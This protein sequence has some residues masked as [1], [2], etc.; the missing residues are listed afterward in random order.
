MDN[1]RI[2]VEDE[3]FIPKRKNTG[4]AGADIKSAVDVVIQPGEA[5]NIP[6]GFKIAIPYQYGGFI[7]PRS[8]LAY[9]HGIR[10]CNGVGVID[11]QYRGEVMLPLRND[12]MKPFAIQRGD[13]LAQLVI[14]KV[15]LPGFVV[16]D[17][18]D[19]TER[20]EG[21]FGSTGVRGE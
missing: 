4:D 17:A 11:H 6:A 2:V 1:L 14:L 16:V 13:R 9:K 5:C 21:G 15:K 19:E 18:L 12:G 7:F 20:G 3:L 10:L 8:G